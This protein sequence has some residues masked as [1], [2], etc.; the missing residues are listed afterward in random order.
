MQVSDRIEQAPACQ[1][2]NLTEAEKDSGL[3][4]GSGWKLARFE[5]GKLAGF[6]DPLEMPW[7]EDTQAMTDEAI[8]AATAWIANAQSEVWLVMCS[9]YQ[10][11]DPRRI[12]L[13]DASALARMARVFSE[14]IQGNF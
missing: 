2:I 10:L 5:S 4:T 13:T 3:Y 9:C 12:T 6:F 8:K 7:N 1:V 14:Q 11:C